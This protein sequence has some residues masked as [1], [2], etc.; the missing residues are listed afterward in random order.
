MTCKGIFSACTQVLR[1][2]GLLEKNVLKKI[3]PRLL[4]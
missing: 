1:D 4:R 3:I 2:L